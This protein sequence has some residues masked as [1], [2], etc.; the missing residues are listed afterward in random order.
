[1]ADS[2]NENNIARLE[3]LANLASRINSKFEE[4]F[5][6][7]AVNGNSVSFFTSKDASGSPAFTFVFPD[8]A[9]KPAN[10]TEGNFATLDKNGNLK[11]SGV[12]FA[13]TEEVNAMLDNILGVQS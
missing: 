5:R 6:S 11:D 13:S 9:T 2:Y 3:D 4:T 10:P 7:A 1:M 12:S 8:S